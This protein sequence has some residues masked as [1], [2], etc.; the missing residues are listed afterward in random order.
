[1]IGK[2]EYLKWKKIYINSDFTKKE[3]RMQG[4]IREKAK[5]EKNKG[6]NVKIG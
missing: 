6:S 4:F 1:M 5:Q 3:R 2:V